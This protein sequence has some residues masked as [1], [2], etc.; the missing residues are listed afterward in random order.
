MCG[1]VG[2]WALGAVARSLERL[3]EVNGEGQKELESPSKPAET[4]ALAYP[5]SPS[6]SRPERSSG[7]RNVHDAGRCLASRQE[8]RQR[9]AQISS[10]KRSGRVA[11]VSL[12]VAWS[13]SAMRAVDGI[14]KVLAAVLTA[15]ADAK[16]DGGSTEKERGGRASER[17]GGRGGPTGYS[18]VADA[19]R[20]GEQDSKGETRGSFVGAG[21]RQEP[22]EDAK[23]E[24]GREEECKAE[25]ENVAPLLRARALLVAKAL[26]LYLRRRYGKEEVQALA[27][28]ALQ[29]C[30]D[31]FQHPVVR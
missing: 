23:T 4:R 29:N 25:E 19:V 1:Q 8:S 11:S 30:G 2:L 24:E 28:L 16:G 22:K 3:P 13:V 14:V 18:G 27:R 5:A 15:P 21:D 10:S 17:G 7:W 26:S 31:A 9:K 6:D 12:P 20:D